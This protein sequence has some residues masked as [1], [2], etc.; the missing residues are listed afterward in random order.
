M[1]ITIAISIL[2][3]PNTTIII[4]GFQGADEAHYNILRYT[5]T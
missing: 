4:S 5:V 1:T 3:I 2:T